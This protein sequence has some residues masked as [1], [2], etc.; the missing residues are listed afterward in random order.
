MKIA[1]TGAAGFIGRNLARRLVERGHRVYSL[2]RPG[3]TTDMAGQ[4]IPLDLHS[5]D[6]LSDFFSRYPVDGV[7][8]LAAHLSRDRG[9]QEFIQHLERNITPSLNLALA[10]PTNLQFACFVGS[11]EEYGNGETPFREDQAPR[12]ISPYGWSKVAI[13]E[14]F[15][16]IANS[17]KIPWFWL[18]PFLTFGP[19]QKSQ[20][21]IPHLIQKCLNNEDIDLTLGEQTRDF[22]YIDDLVAQMTLALENQT[23]LRGEIL[24]LCTGQPRTIRA[25]AE[26]I[27]RLTGSRGHLRFGALPYRTPEAMNFYGSTTKY[28][29]LF[30]E[31]KFT[32]WTES[33]E[34]T[35]AVAA[36]DTGT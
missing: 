6:K 21:L 26:E 25:V 3:Q 33:L 7:V 13:F 30:G 16:L 19:S 35:I 12:V 8:H 22:I 2:V 36:K 15:R 18:R 10:L 11:C 27:H 9:E 17:K 34:M 20:A 5:R 14:G 1:I 31:F 29:N 23:R 4:V 24:N 28:T 32:P